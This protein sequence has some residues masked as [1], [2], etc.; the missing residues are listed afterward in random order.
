MNGSVRVV[1]PKAM[2]L[3]GPSLI[4]ENFNNNYNGGIKWFEHLNPKADSV[5]IALIFEQTEPVLN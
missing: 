1:S 2:I 4:K 3:Y 5:Q